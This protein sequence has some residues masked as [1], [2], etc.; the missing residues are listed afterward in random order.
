MADDVVVHAFSH[1]FT[2]NMFSDS[3]LT[4]PRHSVAD[5]AKPQPA[6]WYVRRISAIANEAQSITL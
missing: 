5:C 3:P 6:Y 2:P 4:G 1:G